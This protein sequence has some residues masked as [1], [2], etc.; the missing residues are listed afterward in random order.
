MIVDF[1]YS[2]AASWPHKGWFSAY[3][4]SVSHKYLFPP[5]KR[6]S[7]SS[8]LSGPT[9]VPPDEHKFH[10]KAALPP[11]QIS[12][13]YIFPYQYYRKHNS[14]FRPCKRTFLNHLYE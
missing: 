3:T 11:P 9:F 4:Y 12:K 14:L 7:P 13:E 8:K 1:P 2:V 5:E 10:A 6:D